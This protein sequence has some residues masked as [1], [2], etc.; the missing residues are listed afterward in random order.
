[1]IPEPVVQVRAGCALPSGISER[2]KITVRD[3]YNVPGWICDEIATGFG[4]TGKLFASVNTPVY[5][6]TLCVPEKL[7]PAVI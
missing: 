2:C 7:S 6:Q 5:H 4:R 1:M 3:H